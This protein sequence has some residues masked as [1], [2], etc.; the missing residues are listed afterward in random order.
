MYGE[1]HS[2]NRFH[3]EFCVD[4]PPHNYFVKLFSP[5]QFGTDQNWSVFSTNG[6]GNPQKKHIIT[7]SFQKPETRNVECIRQNGVLRRAERLSLG[8]KTRQT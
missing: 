7:N 1:T 8:V 6:I 5:D 4:R 3:F 2:N